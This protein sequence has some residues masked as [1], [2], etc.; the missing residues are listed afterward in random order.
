MA[1]T[2]GCGDSF[3]AAVVLGYIQRQPLESVLALSNA[4][5]AATATSPGAGRNVAS[6][7]TVRDLLSRQASSSSAGQFGGWQILLRTEAVCIAR[8]QADIN[9][10]KQ[11]LPPSNTS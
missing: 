8:G 7:D 2:V 3:A 4:V 1:D 9:L 5:G 6:A 10:W 11:L